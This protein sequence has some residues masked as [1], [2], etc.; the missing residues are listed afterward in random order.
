MYHKCSK[1][2]SWWW[3]NCF[4]FLTF[5]YQFPVWYLWL[6]LC[7]F[8]LCLP[9][10]LLMPIS[11]CHP[12]LLSTYLKNYLSTARSQQLI[13][14]CWKYYIAIS[15][16]Q[17]LYIYIYISVSVSCDTKEHQ[18]TFRTAGTAR[19]TATLQTTYQFILTVCS[20]RTWNYKKTVQW[21]PI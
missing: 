21:Q 3:E 5:L 9:M 12:L 13:H 16:I 4:I 10:N 20:V 19:H 15:N 1:L 7:Y 17:Q 8:Y 14:S 6:A 18:Y 2:P 11:L